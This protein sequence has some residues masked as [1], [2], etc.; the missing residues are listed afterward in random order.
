MTGNY[1][2]ALAGT[3]VVAHQLGLAVDELVRRVVE[4]VV[5]RVA[6]EIL[7][8]LV[9]DETGHGLF[10]A[11]PGW[12]FVLQRVLGHGE[13]G[14]LDCRVRVPQPIVAIGAPVAGFMPRVAEKLQTEC[15]IPV[16]AEVG[17]AV[18]AA[19]A[20]VTHTVE[21]LV[22]PHIVGAG[23]LTFRV[24]TPSG[25]EH[26][27]QFPEAVE[28]AEEIAVGL[29]REAVDAAGAEGVSVKVDRREVVLGKL[30]EMTV[31]ATASGRPRLQE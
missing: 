22:Q 14:V 9:G 10:P 7:D 1:A 15:I 24:H 20:S 26:Y 21:I 2:A 6:Q 25:P 19:V 28:H 8:K 30:S 5:D 12:E 31:R 23:T 27:N 4:Y 18:G 13:A 29:A 16:H 17:N 3:R 11:P